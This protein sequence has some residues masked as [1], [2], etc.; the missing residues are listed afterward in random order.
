[1]TRKQKK[2]LH[3]MSGRKKRPCLIPRLRS[4]S[5][6]RFA[7]DDAE[8]FPF[9]SQSVKNHFFDDTVLINVMNLMQFGAFIYKQ[10]HYAFL[11]F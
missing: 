3:G 5:R 6:L 7:R 9:P 1:M 8:G 2:V 11:L 10:R 4:A